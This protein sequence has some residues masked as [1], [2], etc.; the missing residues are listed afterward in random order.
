MS[1]LWMKRYYHIEQTRI[2]SPLNDG[3]GLVG[4]PQH[5][6]KTWYKMANSLANY[7]KDFVNQ[8]QKDNT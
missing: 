3:V 2:L 1:T 8:Q 4:H 6:Q 7:V 5:D